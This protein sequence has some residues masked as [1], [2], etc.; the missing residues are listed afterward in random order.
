MAV[1]AKILLSWVNYVDLDAAI[2]SAQEEVGNLS[3]QNIANPITGRRW[4]STQLNGWAQVDFGS[5]QTVGVLALMFPRDTPI[6]TVG[7]ISHQLDADGGTPGTGAAYSS[8]TTPIDTSE[9]YGYHVHVPA[10]AVSARYWRFTF[11]VSGVTY[12]DVGRAWAGEAWR[13]TFNISLGYEDGWSD[14]S[15]ISASA[16]SGAEFV[17]SRARQRDFAFGLGAL[18][19]AERDD[20][21]EMG[22]LTGISNQLLFVKDPAAPSKETVIGRMA[23]T[24]P[25]LHREIP[26]HSKAFSVRESL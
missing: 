15:R 24:T 6:P 20:I 23:S 14:L 22:R 19:S 21:R 18:S 11:N 2:I 12:I 1:A 13:P 8:P 3:V 7:T 16:R 9:G 25:I 5:D 26:I 10:S 17:D 4:R